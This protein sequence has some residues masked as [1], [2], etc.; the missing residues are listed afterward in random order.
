MKKYETV[1]TLNALRERAELFPEKIAIV[2]RDGQRAISY[3]LFY[4]MMNSYAL[5]MKKT[6]QCKS[7]WGEGIER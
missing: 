5:F 1:H 7:L 6:G 3:G 2:D 4:R